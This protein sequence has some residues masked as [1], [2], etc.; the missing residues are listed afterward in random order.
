MPVSFEPVAT[1]KQQEELAQLA[2]EIWNEYW[3]A[4]IGQAQTT[5]MVEK[6]Q[7]LPAIRRD[8]AENAYEYWF[9]QTA[10]ADE[11]DATAGRRT[12]GFT[13][14]HVEPATNRFFISKVYLLAAE[15]GKGY[16]SATIRHYERL[17]R[18]RGLGAMYLTVNKGNELGIRAYRGNGFTVIDAVETDI[19]QGFIMDDYIMERTV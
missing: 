12:V 13:G 16:A 3:P 10:E 9:V 7:S 6:F 19:G 5:Y 2:A 8:M 17:C 18:E 1:P 11:A 15:R 4:L 14:G